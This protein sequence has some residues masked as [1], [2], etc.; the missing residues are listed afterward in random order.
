MAASRFPNRFGEAHFQTQSKTVQPL[1]IR[2][3]VI[4][5]ENEVGV[6]RIQ[7]KQLEVGFASS[8]QY[9]L[10]LNLL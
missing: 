9:T 4:I 6:I 5:Q 1:N 8:V 2:C 3:W 7:V 10:C